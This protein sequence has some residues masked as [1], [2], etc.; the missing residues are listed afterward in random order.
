MTLGSQPMASVWAIALLR[1]V[2]C[3]SAVKLATRSGGRRSEPVKPMAR[4]AARSLS[5]EVMYVT[6]L[7]FPFAYP[8]APPLLCYSQTAALT[9]TDKIHGP[10]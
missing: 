2:S 3:A 7:L 4:G 5:V 8:Q 10:V 6:I 1:E 9:L